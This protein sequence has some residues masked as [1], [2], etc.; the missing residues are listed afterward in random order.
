MNE[1]IKRANLLI[2]DLQFKG[3]SPTLTSLVLAYNNDLPL[4]QD[5][6]KTEGRKQ[7]KD[8][9]VQGGRVGREGRHV[10]GR[11]ERDVGGR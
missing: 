5:I 7:Y 10:R 8:E 1:P 6:R 4:I 3:Q 11:E 2:A 9:V